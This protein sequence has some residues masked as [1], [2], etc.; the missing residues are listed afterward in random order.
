MANVINFQFYQPRIGE[1]IFR[2]VVTND[3]GEQDIKCLLEDLNN[4]FNGLI[5]SS[6]EVV[7][8][9]PKTKRG[10]QLRLVQEVKEI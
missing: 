2:V 5:D 10:K 7:E 6:V 4:S 9:I 3:F 1:L 8:S